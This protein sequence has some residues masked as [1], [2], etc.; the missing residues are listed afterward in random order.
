MQEDEHGLSEE[1]EI[2]R[3][4]RERKANW[5]YPSPAM[6]Y[7]ALQRKG[8]G[9]P[10]GC[11]PDMVSIHNQMND[12]VWEEIKRMERLLCPRCAEPTLVRFRGRP[13]DLSPLAAW[14]VLVRGGMAPF[15]RHD[16]VISRA[17]I[18]HADV[19]ERA[20]SMDRPG[21][22][23]GPPVDAIRCADPGENTRTVRYVIDFYGGNEDEGHST[24]HVHVRPAVDGPWGLYDRLKLWYRTR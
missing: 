24:F 12:R 16:W 4:P 15:D 10:A 8:K 6:F 14:H 21:G 22:E 7:R 3:I 18:G 19:R 9:V 17:K 20:A 23:D 5:V 11:V 2:S 13:E 1:R